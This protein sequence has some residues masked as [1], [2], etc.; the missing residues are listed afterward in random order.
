M[1]YHR[2]PL[3]NHGCPQCIPQHILPILLCHQLECHLVG[4]EERV[5]VLP[6]HAWESVGVVYEVE[7]TSVDL[8]AEQGKDEDEQEH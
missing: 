1:I 2:Q 7:T 6:G 4:P 3:I 5:V 8:H